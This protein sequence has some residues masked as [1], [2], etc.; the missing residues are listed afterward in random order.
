M[1]K[2]IQESI[3]KLHEPFDDTLIVV[4]NVYGVQNDEEFSGRESQIFPVWLYAR[5]LNKVFADNWTS[6]ISEVE[7]WGQTF[8]SCTIEVFLPDGSKFQR[9]GIPQDE[10]PFAYACELMGVGG[11]SGSILLCSRQLNKTYGLNWDLE[12]KFLEEVVV[13]ELSIGEQGGKVQTRSGLGKSDGDAFT[14]ACEM[15][16]II[17]DEDDDIPF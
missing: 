5:R 1:N 2:A 17:P 13:C 10:Y 3:D 11:D 7:I 4:T 12:L 6:K 15:F 14:D 8:F 9:S 16:G